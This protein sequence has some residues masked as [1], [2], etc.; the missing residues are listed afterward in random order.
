MTPLFETIL[1]HIP[2]PFAKPNEPVP[3]ARLQHRLER[4]RRPDRGRQDPRRQGRAGRPGLG[5]PQ[6]RRRSGSAPRSPRCSSTPAS[7]RTETD[8]SSV[9][10]NIVGLVRLRGHRH[11]R[12][13]RR[14]ARTRTPCPSPR[15]IRRPSRCSSASTTARWS[16]ARA[17]S[18]RRASCATASTARS[19]PTSPSR[20]RTPT[21]PASST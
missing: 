8:A 13:D 19:R 12:H 1:D 10:G 7:A 15:S 5:D 9:A 2:P 17:S 21:G 3:H 18:S 4:L 14:R 20:S 16:A 6:H 11:R